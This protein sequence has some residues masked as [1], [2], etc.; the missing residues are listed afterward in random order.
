MTP[1]AKSTQSKL[2]GLGVVAVEKILKGETV[3]VL[4]GVIIPKSEINQFWKKMGH[5]GI[6]FSDDFFICPT[7][8]EELEEKGV[9]NH[10]CESNCG[11]KNSIELITIKDIK[12]GEELLFD[13]AF[14]ECALEP[15]KCNCGSKNC[16]GIIKPTDW[17][18]PTIQKKLG[19]YFSPYLK[20]KI[21]NI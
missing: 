12:P 4:G 7:T 2:H 16:R 6:Q 15:F 8:K 20:A 5:V 18:I 1:K 10:S 3:G 17:K 14:C 9:F 19:T 11:F 13:Y 21:S